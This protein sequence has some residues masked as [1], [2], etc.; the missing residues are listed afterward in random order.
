M[1]FERLAETRIRQAMAD[2]VFDNLPNA[3]QRLNLDEYFE[4]PEDLRLAHSILKSANCLPEEV[5]LMNEIARLE[6]A[7]A[8]AGDARARN[9][10]A[11]TLEDSRLRLA[12]LM[13][14]RKR[15]RTAASS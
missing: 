11:R 6:R 10:T 14:R 8:S 2:G 9:A 3:G 7:A 1:P 15:H 5:E 4:A 13:E 12:I